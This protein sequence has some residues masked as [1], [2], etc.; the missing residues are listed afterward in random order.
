MYETLNSR[1]Y[2]FL[3]EEDKDILNRISAYSASVIGEVEPGEVRISEQLEVLKPVMQ[4]IADEKKIPL[5]DIFI[6]YMDLASLVLAKKDQQ[7]KED[8]KD[9]Q[10]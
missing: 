8:T 5:E 9:F 3:S 1:D 7:F 2:D 4:E 6:R 10:I